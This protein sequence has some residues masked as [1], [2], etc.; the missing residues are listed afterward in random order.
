MEKREHLV[1]PQRERQVEDF[2][3]DL[4]RHGI[5][6]PQGTFV[7]GGAIEE[8]GARDLADGGAVGR[9]VPPSLGVNG[10]S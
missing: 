6:F 9:P 5:D 10:S 7:A 4:R 1:P 2:V 3:Q 8:E